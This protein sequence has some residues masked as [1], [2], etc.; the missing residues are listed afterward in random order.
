[1]FLFATGASWCGLQPFG[2]IWPRLARGARQAVPL[3]DDALVEHQ[4]GDQRDAS[5]AGRRD[6]LVQLLQRRPEGLARVHRRLHIYE[7]AQGRARSGQHGA[8]LQA[9]WRLGRAMMIGLA[10]I[11]QS[12]VDVWNTKPIALKPR[13]FP[14]QTSPSG[15]LGP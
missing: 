15:Q 5:G 7:Y 9:H 1:M 12:H 14:D 10:L 6:H 13:P 8:F 2:A 11:D 3:L 4:L